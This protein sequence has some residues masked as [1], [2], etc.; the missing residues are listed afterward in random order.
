MIKK[1]SLGDDSLVVKRIMRRIVGFTIISVTFG[2]YI[3]ALPIIFVFLGSMIGVYAD[4][5]YDDANT[6]V[7]VL[8]SV[9]LMAPTIYA[10]IRWCQY[11][12]SD[13]I[14]KDIAE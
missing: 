2:M 5:I 1:N 8:T 12:W 9:G 6:I 4:T 11:I 7:W 14:K 13:F 10:L 3:Q